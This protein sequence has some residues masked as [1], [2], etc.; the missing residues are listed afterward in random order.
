MSDIGFAIEGGEILGLIGPNGSGKSTVMKLIMGIE[1][2]N[3]GSVR[4]E[5]AEM[6]GWP[7]HRIARSGIGIV[8]QHSRPLHRQTVLENIKLALLPDSLLKLAA[9]PHVDAK[10][11]AIAER[12]GLGAVMDRHPST[13]PFADLR[14]ME[15]AKA[16][17]RDPKVV[18]VD[19][20]FAGLTSGEVRAFSEL[21]DGF[22]REGRAVLLVD[23]NVKGVAALVDRVLAMYL[24]ERI[25]EGS[26]DEV[27]RNET[28]RRVYLGGA[29]ETHARAGG[30]G[31]HRARRSSR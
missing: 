10:A 8:F 22:R 27:M 23:H 31:E 15:M 16:I 1:R 14:R 20:P 24:G 21:I 13:L 30:G 2:P 25:A 3:A 9:E 5:G 29:I 6:A 11:R 17:A 4:L 19:E 18:L 7:S 28:V 26:A 12:V